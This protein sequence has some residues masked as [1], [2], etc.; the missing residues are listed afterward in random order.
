M[1]FISAHIRPTIDLPPATETVKNLDLDGM[2]Q[3]D[4]ATNELSTATG[5]DR[6]SAKRTDTCGTKDNRSDE[7]YGMLLKPSPPNQTGDLPLNRRR[8]NWLQQ[9]R[10]KWCQTSNGMF[11]R[12]GL[13]R[14]IQIR[15]I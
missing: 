4:K 7:I 2:V 9:Y 14:D 12:N 6:I 5:N 15:K 13:A 1:I 8:D 3:T 11:D 10:R